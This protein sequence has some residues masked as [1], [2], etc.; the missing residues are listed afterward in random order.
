MPFL[1]NLACHD[2]TSGWCTLVGATGVGALGTFL[3]QSGL[4]EVFKAGH[5]PTA[6]VSFFPAGR[7]V[8]KNGGYRVSGLWRL[9]N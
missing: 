6:A 1:E 4:D 2:M 5:V 3:T 8:G 9:F 7:A